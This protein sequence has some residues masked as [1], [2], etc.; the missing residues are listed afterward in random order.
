[1]HRRP[2]R[3]VAVLAAA[4]VLAACGGEPPRG[5]VATVDGDEVP[6][7][8]LEDW[9]RTATDA[10]PALDE[11]AVQRDLLSRLLQNRIVLGV[12][13]DRGL[14][15][16]DAAVAAVAVEVEE[17]VGGAEALAATLA[18]IG[19]PQGFYEEVFLTTEAALDVLTTDLLGDRTLETR[20]ARHILVET[21]AEADEIV[22]LLADGADFAALATERSTDP[23]SAAQGGLL[24]ER[25]R[26]AFVPEFDAAVW[27]A[28]LDTVLD[29][30][31]T[32]FGFHVIEVVA[33]ASTAVADLPSAERRRLV[34]PELDAILGGAV[35][36][37][38]VTVASRLGVWD[39][40][41]GAV[42]APQAV[43]A[44][45]W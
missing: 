42:T 29:P 20:T 1:M 37:A 19:Y 30:V 12:L 27:D 41:A 22:A 4:L 43:G 25:E 39:G 17:Q 32:Q 31:E 35:A 5:A 15:V 6:S 45:R 44:D 9:V 8:Q 40:V 33:E 38:E 11:V 16:D 26:G 2:R 34:G 23:G 3:A 18:D 24:G 36:A 7:A 14:V 28:R 21:A 10:N 13:A